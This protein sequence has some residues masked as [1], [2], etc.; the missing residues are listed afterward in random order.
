V[1]A[2]NVFVELLYATAPPTRHGIG[3]QTPATQ[4]S[5]V[6]DEVEVTIAVSPAVLLL[7]AG[8]LAGEL[9]ISSTA[10]T[11][12]APGDVG[13]SVAVGLETPLHPIVTR[14]LRTATVLT[15]FKFIPCVFISN[16]S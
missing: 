11:P 6:L 5:S 15:S 12:L 13:G 1:Q 16:P 3:T 4:V 14:P 7:Q 2:H 9:D 10:Y 8:K